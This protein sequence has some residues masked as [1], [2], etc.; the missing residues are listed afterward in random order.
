[1]SQSTD[2]VAR[3]S[4]QERMF[5][6]QLLDA[7]TSIAA[8]DPLPKQATTYRRSPPARLLA[9]A[10]GLL[11][12]AVT[13][14]IAWQPSR[15]LSQAQNGSL[16]Q[17]P[18]PSSAAMP[19]QRWIIKPQ[20]L[21][22]TPV[23]SENLA[24]YTNA[25]DDYKPLA[26][27]AQLRRLMILGDGIPEPTA[28]S[29]VPLGKLAKLEELEL[30]LQDEMLPDHLRALAKA[31]QVHS[32]RL[33]CKRVMTQAD[34][35]TLKAMPAL[36]TLTVFGG[37]LDAATVR[38]L[39][40][41]PHL[42][43]LNL[44][45]VA[46]CTEQV[47]TQLRMLHRLRRLGLSSMGE[48][49]LVTQLGETPT[50]GAGLTPAVAMALRDLPLLQ[51]LKLVSCKVT[52]AALAALPS[53]LRR[54][55]IV[56]CPDTYPADVL[57]LRHCRNLTEVSFDNHDVTRWL[58]AMPQDFLREPAQ[59]G[60]AQAELIRNLALTHFDYASTM[61]NAV[62]LAIASKPSLTHVKLLWFERDDLDAL[63]NVKNLKHLTLDEG[64]AV[65][66][67]NLQVLTRCES[68]ETLTVRHHDWQPAELQRMLPGV[69]V[70]TF[71]H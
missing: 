31:K 69:T 37:E 68:L 3:A 16:A 62:R 59:L 36:R 40:E 5:D 11:G 64:R 45:S 12:L 17:N 70:R 67:Q 14:L 58:H 55:C 61:P 46:A 71:Q 24:V 42:D 41:L 63:A 49:L 66:L 65:E 22:T 13:V 29:L 30:P 18:T 48:Q 26:G 1:M 27:F 51:E 33:H 7:L 9:A 19:A 50:P 34:V 2:E 6:V 35:Q 54:I 60:D 28:N 20:D 8:A 47:L 39:S 15:P 21:A 38:S 56:R 53:G 23:N 25:I 52:T 4:A 10:I 32:L 43:E 44:Q 57:A